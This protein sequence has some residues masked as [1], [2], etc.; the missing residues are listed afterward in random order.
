LHKTRRE[1][2]Q[3]ID[4]PKNLLVQDHTYL[5]DKYAI[6]VRSFYK[7][8]LAYVGTYK[9]Y[10]RLKS[11]DFPGKYSVQDFIT[12]EIRSTL[13]IKQLLGRR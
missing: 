4:F 7:S 1:I 6:E 2:E 3:P 5:Q 12:F 8:Y 10:S 13:E 11:A 9:I